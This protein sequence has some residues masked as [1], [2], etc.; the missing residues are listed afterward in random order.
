MRRLFLFWKASWI[1]LFLFSTDVA[2][3]NT[4]VVNERMTTIGNTFEFDQTPSVTTAGQSR[5]TR[6][7][8]L[9]APSELPPTVCIDLNLVGGNILYIFSR[10]TLTS[11]IHN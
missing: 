10:M 11:Q 3:T 2:V 7:R 9:S 4:Q 8:S 5:I 6:Q 1:L